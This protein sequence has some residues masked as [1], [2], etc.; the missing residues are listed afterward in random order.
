[1]L[2]I[3]AKKVETVDADQPRPGVGW[4]MVDTIHIRREELMVD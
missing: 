4:I 3:P 1:M 2:V